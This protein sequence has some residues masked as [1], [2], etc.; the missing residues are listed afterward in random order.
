[1]DQELPLFQRKWPLLAQRFMYG[2][3]PL[4]TGLFIRD[5]RSLNTVIIDH[6]QQDSSYRRV[7]TTKRRPFTVHY[8]DEDA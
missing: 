5:Q 7:F 3:I 8:H 2:H 1:M 4:T 6:L